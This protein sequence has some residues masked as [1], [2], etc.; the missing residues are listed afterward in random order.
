[1]TADAGD[2]T[3]AA[4]SIGDP[5]TGDPL[6]A[7]VPEHPRRLVYLGTPEAAVPPLQALVEAGFELAAVVTRGDK[8]R[9]RGGTLT[10]SPVKSA[11][12]ALGLPV[13]HEVDEV[14]GLG[15]DLGVVVAF[16]QLIRP[17]VLAEV[18]MVNLHFSLLPRWRGA[19]PVERALLA[20]DRETGVC[21]MQVEHGLDTGGV[22]AREVV[23]IGERVTAAELRAELVSV[24]AQL[25]VDSLTAGLGAPQPQHGEAVYAAK[26]DPAEL[27]IDWSR[28]A[29][30]LDR[31]I[32]LGGAWSTF[33]SKR[34]KIVAAEPVD[35]EQFTPE[36]LERPAD[37]G[38]LS[39]DGIVTCGAG[40]LV[41]RAVQPEGKA[42]M[43]FAAWANGARP[44]PN[45]RFG[46]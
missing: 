28:P 31:L 19:A 24:G 32:R 42:P 3:P 13:H 5:S 33:R 41:L 25:L 9:G 2:P 36:H 21:L 11:A 14:L 30:E 23:P 16:G 44:Q 26:I 15:A 17:H 18:P 34:I 37:P 8:R 29:I 12:L 1:M 20:G 10:P 40:A 27:R 22:F 43:P 35:H 4:P 45:E 46:P 38:S 39:A 7:P 6:L